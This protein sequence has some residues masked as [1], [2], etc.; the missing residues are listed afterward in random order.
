MFISSLVKFKNSFL[1][2]GV[3]DQEEDLFR[4]VV[5]T[6]TERLQQEAS[7]APLPPADF[8]RDCSAEEAKHEGTRGD[9][10]LKSTLA[11]CTAHLHNN[12]NCFRDGVSTY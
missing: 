10:V 6:Q 4:V 2:R 7:A 5:Q 9:V 12:I 3:T 11:Y 1:P 8:T